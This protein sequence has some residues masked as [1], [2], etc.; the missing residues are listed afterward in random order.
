[1]CWMQTGVILSVQKCCD[2]VVLVWFCLVLRCPDS[3]W[4]VWP[5]GSRAK[6]SP[7]LEGKT[8][9]KIVKVASTNMVIYI[10]IYIKWDIH[11]SYDIQCG[12]SIWDT[13]YI[14][15]Y[16][17]NHKC[18]LTQRLRSPCFQLYT[19]FQKPLLCNRRIYCICHI[20]SYMCVLLRLA[21]FALLTH[22]TTFTVKF[23]QDAWTLL[24]KS[25]KL[26]Q[27]WPRHNTRR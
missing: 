23:L 4:K 27:T 22:Q 25:R 9:Q 15:I 18:S 26:V 6:K 14:Y 20:W 5:Q 1:M 3:I 16:M 2:D 17:Y 21:P 13:E 19:M 7:G 24:Y 10:Y 8:S 11:I 12:G